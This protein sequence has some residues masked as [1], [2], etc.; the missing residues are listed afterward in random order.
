M[1]KI[2]DSS[3][4]SYSLMTSPSSS[5]WASLTYLPVR[6]S[7]TSIWRFG[8][9]CVK[10]LTI[11]WAA[12]CPTKSRAYF[13]MSPLSLKM[14]LLEPPQRV[15]CVF[16]V[17]RSASSDRLGLMSS[18]YNRR[19]LLSCGGRKTSVQVSRMHNRNRRS[20]AR[21]APILAQK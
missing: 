15:A 10:L 17:N 5:T 20:V 13:S 6:T 8:Y 11:L 2:S 18:S 16:E 4:D 7:N 9:S 1:S 3:S 21:S 12:M 19:S 14:S